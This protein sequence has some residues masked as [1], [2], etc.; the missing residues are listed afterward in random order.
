LVILGLI[1]RLEPGPDVV[2]NVAYFGFHV[3]FRDALALGC[4]NVPAGKLGNV[5]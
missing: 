1:G 4:L 5:L 3:A 2:S